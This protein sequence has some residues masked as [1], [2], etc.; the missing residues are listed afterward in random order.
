M[1]RAAPEAFGPLLRRLRE[2]AGLPQIGLA[3]AVG[4]NSGYISRLEAGER[5]APGVELVRA[6]ADALRLA[7]AERDSLLAAAG[8]LPPSL[9]QIEA[10]DPTLALVIGILGDETIPAA[11]REE[12]RAI[13]RL[14]A[15]RWRPDA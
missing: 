2:A 15:R 8:Y 11:Q 5:S 4:V 1:S 7:P 13:V 14:V 3:R 6:V 12:F 9:A 10:G